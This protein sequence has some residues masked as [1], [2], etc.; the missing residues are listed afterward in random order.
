MKKFVIIVVV[1]GFVFVFCKK[2]YF[3][4][5]KMFDGIVVVIGIFKVSKKDVINFCDVLEI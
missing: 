2:D 1:V 4:F 5:C 3:C